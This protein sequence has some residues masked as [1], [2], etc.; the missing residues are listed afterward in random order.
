MNVA[1]LIWTIRCSSENFKQKS[2]E[3]DIVEV[4]KRW[5]KSWQGYDLLQTNTR[6]DYTLKELKQGMKRLRTKKIAVFDTLY[7]KNGKLAGKGWFLC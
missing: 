3:K 6:H 4:L 7:H 2:I 5:N 1:K